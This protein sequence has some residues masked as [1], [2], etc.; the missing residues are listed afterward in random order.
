M[1]AAKTQDRSIRSLLLEGGVIV[2]SIL[3]AFALDALWDETK[4]GREAQI[5]LTSLKDEF[6]ANLAAC[7]EVEQ[8]YHAMAKQFAEVLTMSDERVRALGDA[9]ATVAYN[10]F[11]APRTFD[12][13]LGT[14]NSVIS[15]GT[16]SILQD[17]ELRKALD[18]FLNFVEDS[19]EDV[20]NL[21]HYMRLIGEY[22]VAFGGP[23]GGAAAP[24]GP[25]GG[26]AVA[27]VTRPITPA[28]LLRLLRDPG[29]V[30]RA[31]LFHGCAN[32]YGTEL[33]RMAAQS[34]A[35]LAAIAKLQ[36]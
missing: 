29:Y 15:T 32:W 5:A 16:F 13:M 2:V 19:R 8:H 30:G 25:D 1:T 6:E 9:E 22:E 36:S 17:A 18:T 35:V 21:L 24:V 31:K 14:T 23:W 20:G 12:A 28:E 11:C 3:L 7:E 34:R 26:G 33:A 10:S 4:R 27:P